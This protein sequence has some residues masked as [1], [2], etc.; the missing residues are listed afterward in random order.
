MGDARGALRGG[1]PG[2]PLSANG[3]WH[4]AAMPLQVGERPQCGACA[5]RSDA[6]SGGTKTNGG[7]ARALLRFLRDP[8]SSI[9]GSYVGSLERPFS[10]ARRFGRQSKAGS[11]PYRNSYANRL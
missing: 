5:S 7:Q 2:G 11:E 9:L 6:Y 1:I 3:R 4:V 10:L 8:A